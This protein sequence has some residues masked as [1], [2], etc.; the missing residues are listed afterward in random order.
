MGV[1]V[2]GR[3]SG[4]FRRS[5][6]YWRPIWK[7]T[8]DVTPDLTE[9]QK[10]AGFFNDGIRISKSAAARMAVAL[11]LIRQL[12]MRQR[13]R[14]VSDAVEAFGEHYGMDEEDLEEWVE[15]LEDCGGFEVW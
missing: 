7:L 10:G 5:W 4:F 1:D 15:F 12:P 3:R 2:I 14:M 8:I 11:K 6:W 13:K 9:R